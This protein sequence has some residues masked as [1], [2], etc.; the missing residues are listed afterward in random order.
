MKKICI[1]AAALLFAASARASEP[2]RI[3]FDMPT[4][5]AGS[6]LWAGG[7]DPEWESK[8]LPVGNG[9]LGAN[10]M[11]SISRER[12]TLNEKSLWTGGPAVTDDPSYYWDCNRPSAALLPEIR[13]ESEPSCQFPACGLIEDDYIEFDDEYINKALKI[14]AMGGGALRLYDNSG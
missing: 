6:A 5:S 14:G 10:V 8:S 2:L 3:W 1:I 9:S 7:V 11:G 12:L 13:Q 4:S